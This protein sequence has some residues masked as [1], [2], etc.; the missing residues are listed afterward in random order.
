MLQQQEFARAVGLFVDPL[1][2]R[3]SGHKQQQQP[4]GGA[5]QEGRSNLGQGQ[6]HCGGLAHETLS[7]WRV[8][9]GQVRLVA[10]FGPGSGG[11]SGQRV[12]Q[13]AARHEAATRARSY[14]H[15]GA[16]DRGAENGG[17]RSIF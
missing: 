1:A 3:T 11:R 2:S 4:Q 5:G 7:P 12:A 6:A 10:A 8:K 9:F 13:E 17:K 14:A 15:C 16:E